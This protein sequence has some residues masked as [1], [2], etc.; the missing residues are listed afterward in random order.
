[1][2]QINDDKSIYVTRGD[3]VLFTVSAEDRITK[4]P[5][6]FQPGDLVRIK[7]FA[8]KNC[9]NVVLQKDFA[10][11]SAIEHVEIFL[12]RKDTKIGE[13][14]N[15]PT[16]YWYEIEL[17]A[18]SDPQTIVGYNEDGPTLFMLYPEGRDLEADD[19]AIKHEDIPIVDDEFDLSSNRPIANKTVTRAI[20][21]IH[22]EFEN[23]WKYASENKA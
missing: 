5:Y 3:I 11:T 7:V 16:P 8:K 22:A 9:E 6:I 18:L 14:I 2:Y 4:E 21:R 20:I 23:V 15:K 19:P 10:V 1:M 12:D 17:N 13:V